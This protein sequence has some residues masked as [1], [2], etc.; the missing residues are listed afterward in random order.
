MAKSYPNEEKDAWDV[1]MLLEVGGGPGRDAVATT[2]DFLG[3]GEG[4]GPCLLTKGHVRKGSA[5]TCPL[6][7]G[8]QPE[9][10]KA[11]PTRAQSRVLT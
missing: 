2:C 1:K 3:V 8:Q 10:Q 9:G 4:T 5:V 7:Q 6:Q 11:V